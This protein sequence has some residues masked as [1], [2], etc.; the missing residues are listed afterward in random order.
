M[1][2]PDASQE[3]VLSVH[4]P[5][6]LSALETALAVPASTGDAVARALAEPLAAFS[7]TVEP[8]GP[9]RV[10]IRLSRAHGPTSAQRVAQWIAARVGARV[11]RRPR[12][13]IGPNVLVARM[14]AR[15]ADSGGIVIFDVARYREV[16]GGWRVRELSGVTKR[17]ERRLMARGV[18]TIGQLARANADALGLGVAG[19]VLCER[20]RGVEPR[21]AIELAPVVATRTGAGRLEAGAV[22]TSRPPIERECEAA[23]E[24]LISG[25]FGARVRAKLFR[26]GRSGE[27]KVMPI[28]ALRRSA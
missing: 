4:M 16:A 25:T 8:S 24:R 1:R 14:A 27:W 5:G 15:T 28:E 20:A 7:P 11:G 26:E 19:R 6:L 22:A 2:T 13:G 9:D 21:T 23:I 3:F 18:F 10:T 17:V 12:I